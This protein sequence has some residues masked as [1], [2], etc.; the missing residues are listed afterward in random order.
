MRTFI[1]R[2]LILGIFITFSGAMVMY[3]VIR[4]LPTSYVETIARQRASNPL[5]TRTYQEWLDQLNEIYGL[6]KGIAAG[7]FGWIGNAVKGDFGDSWHYGIPVTE[8]FKQV[9]WYSVIINILTLATQVVIAIPVGI[10]AAHLLPGDASEVR[11]CHKT[12]LV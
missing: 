2:R 1:I 12:G 9:I 4:C 6:D 8:K 10:I 7:F 3:T 5:S 11:F